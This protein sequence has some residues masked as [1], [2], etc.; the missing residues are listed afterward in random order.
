MTRSNRKTDL[1]SLQSATQSTTGSSSSSSSSAVARSSRGRIGGAL[2]SQPRL[3]QF[4]LSVHNSPILFCLSPPAATF[5]RPSP[6]AHLTR[7]STRG[8][9]SAAARL[10]SQSAHSPSSAGS[11]SSGPSPGLGAAALVS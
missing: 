7:S 8:P 4:H 6:P 11:S 9:Q 10:S 2:V 1:P 5:A 3:L